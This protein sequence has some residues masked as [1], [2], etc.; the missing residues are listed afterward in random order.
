[1][2]VILRKLVIVIINHTDL[3]LK[4]HVNVKIQSFQHK[5]KDTLFRKSNQNFFNFSH[6][7]KLKHNKSRWVK[8]KNTFSPAADQEEKHFGIHGTF[9]GWRTKSPSARWSNWEAHRPITGPCCPAWRLRGCG[10]GCRGWTSSWTTSP[11]C[12]PAWAACGNWRRWARTAASVWGNHLRCWR[13]RSRPRRRDWRRRCWSTVIGRAWC[14]PGKE[15]G[16]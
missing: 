7:L 8:K 10:G 5:F 1:M 11:P 6:I 16:L 4:K 12:D 9:R 3:K 14:R 2:W 13:E 15:F